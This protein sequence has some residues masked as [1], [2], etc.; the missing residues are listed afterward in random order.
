MTTYAQ[1]RPMAASQSRALQYMTAT[2]ENL[3]QW[4][5]HDL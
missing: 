3:D 4:D 1:N 2:Q 5:A